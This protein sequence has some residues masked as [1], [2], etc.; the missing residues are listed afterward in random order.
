MVVCVT[1]TYLSSSKSQSQ[2]MGPYYLSNNFSRELTMLHA[3]IF[4]G[5]FY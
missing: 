3:K 2:G 5:S 1:Q 4:Y